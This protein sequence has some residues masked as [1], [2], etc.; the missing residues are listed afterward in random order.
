MGEGYEGVL[1][2]G[3]SECTSDPTIHSSGNS[4]SQCMKK[5]V[6]NKSLNGEAK[7]S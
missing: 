3:G 1:R 5:K 2:G 6:R 7:S 4:V